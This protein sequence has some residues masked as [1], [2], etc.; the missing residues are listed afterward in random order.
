M[1]IRIRNKC[2]STCLMSAAAAAVRVV[3]TGEIFSQLARKSD[4]LGHKLSE[5]LACA[6]NSSKGMR[7]LRRRLLEA[8][9]AIRMGS[10]QGE[11]LCNRLLIYN[12]GMIISWICNNP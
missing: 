5:L 6:E 4:G 10:V 11:Q 1:Q 3:L 8:A 7:P 9:L 2:I 12:C